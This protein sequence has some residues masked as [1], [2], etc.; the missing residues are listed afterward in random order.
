[1]N[2]R[3]LYYLDPKS[4]SLEKNLEILNIWSSFLSVRKEFD[5][6]NKD[7]QLGTFPRDYQKD[8]HNCGII[9]LLFFENFIKNIFNTYFNCEILTALR[10]DLFV[11][12]KN[13]SKPHSDFCLKCGQYD[14]KELKDNRFVK[15]SLG[16]SRQCHF[17]CIVREIFTCSFCTLSPV[18]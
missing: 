12:M 3:V 9:C 16:C 17:E 5:H 11:F 10:K 4:D 15:C 13:N 8:S 18:T 2:S 6:V 1:M 14:R 7:W